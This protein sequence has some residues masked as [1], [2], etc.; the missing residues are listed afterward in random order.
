MARLRL[1]IALAFA[2][3]LAGC[4]ALEQPQNFISFTW[5]GVQYLFTASAATEAQ[6][7]AVDHP[8]AVGYIDGSNPPF[9]YVITG[10]ATADDAEAGT[11]TIVINF[12]QDGDWYATARFYDSEGT[13]VWMFLSQI[14]EGMFDAFIS[15]RDAV[16]EQFA[17]SMPGPFDEGGTTPVHELKNIIFSVERLPNQTYQLPQ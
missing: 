17:G 16:G 3:A 6:P 14:P 10:S 15:N 2:L 13:E 8:C 5:D 11:N 9:E 12:G 7:W 1:L 4:P